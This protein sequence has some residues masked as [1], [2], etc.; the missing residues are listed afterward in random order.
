[1]DYNSKLATMF[2]HPKKSSSAK[3]VILTRENRCNKSQNPVVMWQFTEPNQIKLKGIVWIWCEFLHV[4]FCSFDFTPWIEKEILQ[5]SI[6]ELHFCSCYSQ[7][8]IET[9]STDNKM[10]HPLRSGS[11][12]E[13]ILDPCHSSGPSVLISLK[14]DTGSL[15]WTV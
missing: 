5:K 7:L 9:A 12:S 1:M 3:Y 11:T 15:F 6:W 8:L 14:P 2:I 4:G 10:Q 13:T